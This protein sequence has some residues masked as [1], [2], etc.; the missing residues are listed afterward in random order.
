ADAEQWWQVPRCFRAKRSSFPLAVGGARC[1]LR[2]P[3]QRR[4]PGYR[5]QLQQ[6]SGAGTAK[7][8]RKRK[9]LAAGQIS[10]VAE[11]PGWHRHTSAS[12]VA[13]GASTVRVRE[14]G[15]QLS[16]GQRS[17]RAF[18][19]RCGTLGSPARDLVAERDS[20]TH[21]EGGYRS[22]AYSPR[23]RILAISSALDF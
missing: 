6:W 22:S 2:R 8:G 9:S 12:R 5:D 16:L 15:W 23:T 4:L 17:P 7:P 10:G 13:I 11:Q 1:G 20:T 19:A 14:R 18:R 21:R 3:R